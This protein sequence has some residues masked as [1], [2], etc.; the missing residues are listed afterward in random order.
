MQP[1]Y[2][3]SEGAVELRN[4]GGR[5]FEAAGEGREVVVATAQDIKAF[6]GDAAAG[7]A[8]HA[9][10]GVYLL[11]SG[12]STGV[13]ET[14]ALAGVGYT[15][16]MALSSFAYRLPPEGYAPAGVK[17][18]VDASSSQISEHSVSVEQA[19]RTPQFYLMY[20][21]MLS[22]A[23]GAY[24]FLATGK[25]L[26]SD[27]FAGAMPAIVT[28]TFAGAFVAAMSFAN[29]GGR[30]MY[31]NAS[32]ELSRRTGKP[33]FWA[34]KQIFTFM[35]G[36]GPPCYL[37]SIWAVHNVA[38]DRVAP[39]AVFTFSVLA[40]IASFGGTA[41]TRPAMTADVFGTKNVAVLTARQLTC[42]LPASFLGPRAVAFF[43][44]RSSSDA[45]TSLAS[46]ADPVAFQK[47]F[48]VIP[49]P[50]TVQS[51]IDAKT[52]TIARLMDIMP[53]GTVDPTPTLY[54]ET[55]MVMAGLQ[56]RR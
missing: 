22:A 30:L 11:D 33:P 41:A 52:L 24:G 44:D 51:L 2:L 47:A 39:L 27:C 54:D 42:V 46:E 16:A 18:E 21:G 49:D 10:A 12:G 4:E 29:M 9:E 38:P 31:S 55:F 7:A 3:G 37:A 17:E 23:T 53:P 5:L 40:I 50:T 43:R 48:G 28:G 34:R 15:A 8:T 1:E 25:T 32:D 6:L 35:W 20:F 14:F 19:M 45:M 56:V 13:A 36:V 26:M